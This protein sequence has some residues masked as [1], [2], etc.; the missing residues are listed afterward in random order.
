[1]EAL[2]SNGGEAMSKNLIA[3]NRRAKKCNFKP[4]LTSP[5]LDRFLT[6]SPAS[7]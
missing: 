5:E 6:K 7:P 2:Y 1:V 4:L 3:S